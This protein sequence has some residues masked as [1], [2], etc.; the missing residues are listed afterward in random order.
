MTEMWQ[1]GERARKAWITFNPTTPLPTTSTRSPASGRRLSTVCT[2][3]ASG[4]TERRLVIAEV[5][6]HGVDFTLVG[7]VAIAPAAAHAPRPRQRRRI[8]AQAVIS[9]LAGPAERLDFLAATGG[10]GKARV[11]NHPVAHAR[12]SDIRP[13]LGD[14]AHHFVSEIE[15][16]VAGRRCGR[17]AWVGIHI[18]QRQIG[19]ADAAHPI[20]H[21]QPAGAGQVGFGQVLEPCRRERRE[22]DVPPD[23][24]D[25]LDQQ[26][27]GD[28]FVEVDGAHEKV[29]GS[30]ETSRP[31]NWG[32]GGHGLA[33]RDTDC[34]W[35]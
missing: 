16:G 1:S 4:S 11:H 18:Q 15:A 14:C 10:I 24:F 19:G 5:V 12:A 21:A 17:D 30:Q 31:G 28:V 23:G 8:F 7:D 22:H 2:A 25:G 20:L 13:S 6:G 9:F 34:F 32:G 35:F 29:V 3:T 26:A 33:R 27:L